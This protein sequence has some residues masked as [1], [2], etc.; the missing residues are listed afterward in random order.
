MDFVTEVFKLIPLKASLVIM[1]ISWLISKQ[2]PRDLNG[3]L[4]NWFPFVPLAL[5]LIA[6]IPEYLLGNVDLVATQPVWVTV[7]NAA[8]QGIV[9]GAVAIGLWSARGS[10][11]Y[12]NKVVD[13]K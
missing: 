9:Y 10:I 13:D 5:G 8:A 6:G 1:F 3:R 12:F 2:I 11:P 7:L 4:P